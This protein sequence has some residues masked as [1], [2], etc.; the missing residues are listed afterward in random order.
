MDYKIGIDVDGVLANS[1]GCLMSSLNSEFGTSHTLAEITRWD[2]YE[3]LWPISRE[4]FYRRFDK[5]WR[6]NWGSIL[7]EEPRIKVI[8]RLLR[9]RGHRVIIITK[10]SPNT[11]PA[12]LAWLDMWQIP[13]DDFV[14]VGHDGNKFN[15]G[16][17]ILVD[18]HPKI[19]EHHRAAFKNTLVC[20][21]D[22]PWNRHIN[23]D[24]S[25]GLSQRIHSLQELP[26]LTKLW[27]SEV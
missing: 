2:T 22:Q 3:D 24:S 15:F 19:F 13:F 20:L 6:H 27:D 16:L 11:V 4:D 7:R 1:A 14:S 18:D 21:R 26:A 10:R 5:M 12:V 8:L 9:R 25:Y 17:D 23:I